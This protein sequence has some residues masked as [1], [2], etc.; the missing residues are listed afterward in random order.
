MSHIYHPNLGDPS[1]PAILVDGCPSCEDHAKNPVGGLDERF[2]AA[3]WR[4]MVAVEHE[5]PDY[6]RSEAELEAGRQFF[7]IACFLERHTDID[8]W[9][10]FTAPEPTP[11]EPRLPGEAER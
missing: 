5:D 8:P 3:M 1:R 11:G 7:R 10:L 2:T 4:K 9:M 6:Y